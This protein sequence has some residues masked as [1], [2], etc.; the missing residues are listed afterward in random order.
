MIDHLICKNNNT[1]LEAMQIINDNEMCM[2]FVVDEFNL[3]QGVVTDG[4]IRRA[5]LNKT[6]LNSPVK[7]ILHDDFVYGVQGDTSTE[8]ISKI[9]NT[10]SIIPIVDEDNK[11]VDCFR[12]S[13]NV[14]FPVSIPNLYGNEFKYLTDAFF[15]TWI[16]SK[17]D[18]IDKFEEV[19]S[20][21]SDCCHG[22][23]VSNGTAALHLSLVALG[24][25]VGDEVI[26][27]DLTFAATINAVLYTNAKPVIVDVEK[28]S[29]CIDPVKIEEAITPKTKAVI[30]VHIYG[31]VCD[32]EAI[33]KIA[34][35]YKIKVVEDCA[36]AHGAK[37]NNRKVGSF[38]DIGCFSFYG[39]KVITTGEGGMCT[40]NSKKLNSK[41]RKLRD[42]GMSKSRRYYHDVVGFN[43]RMTNLQ[44]AI[45]LAQLERID[46]IHKNRLSYEK[47]YHKMMC[48][49]SFEFQ[50]RL[51]NRKRITWLVSILA[52]NE[53]ERDGVIEKMVENGIDARP[54]FCLLSS[55]KIYSQYVKTNNLVARD[56]S[57]RGVNLPTYESLKKI[58]QLEEIIVKIL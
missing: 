14:H 43:Y 49:T 29:W 30:P 8:L 21:Y 6:D 45:G 35:K 12:Y 33:M 55:M 46:E 44:A 27:P 42:H 10:I 17:G 34:K 54:F 23:C 58:Q 22:V 50:K 53:K 41:L 3:L 25:G 31:Q 52:K 7:E 24:V 13:Q 48:K 39:N 56:I 5:I 28:D 47:A 9:N 38:G 16:S 15:S 57:T 37:Y 18:Y 4:D 1:L 32:M 20:S 36:E 40:T 2:C 51:K 11:L 19:F 26:V